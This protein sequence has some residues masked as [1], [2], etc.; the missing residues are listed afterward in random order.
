M[1]TFQNLRSMVSSVI[2]ISTVLI[3][4][5]LM[6]NGCS[7]NNDMTS[8]SLASSTPRIAGFYQT[9]LE[10]S[11]VE[12]YMYYSTNGTALSYSLNDSMNCFETIQYVVSPTGSETDEYVVREADVENS[13]EVLQ[14]IVRSSEDL[15]VSYQEGEESVEYLWPVEEGIAREDLQICAEM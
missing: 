13:V 4:V 7:S 12:S 1:H 5:S 10:G 11:G 8:S 14:A 3:S 15:S 6:L 2:R 9:T